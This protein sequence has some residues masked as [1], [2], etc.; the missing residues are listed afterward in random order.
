MKHPLE[1][2]SLTPIGYVFPLSRKRVF[3]KLS[4]N[5]VNGD[6]FAARFWQNKNHLKVKEARPAEVIIH[7]IMPSLSGQGHTKKGDFEFV[8]KQ[9]KSRDIMVL[10]TFMQWFGTNVGSCFIDTVPFG[11]KISHS[12][13]E[14]KEKFSFENKGDTIIASKIHIC[15][16]NCGPS[17]LAVGWHCQKTPESVTGRDRVV[18][19]ALMHWLGT[20]AGRQYMNEYRRYIKRICTLAHKKR[21]ELVKAA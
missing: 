2:S 1:N 16:E 19:N 6:Y 14:F 18:V 20:K 15:T 8:G 3:Q 9:Y 7:S 4:N 12:L 5:F 11:V 17:F 13:R 21:L 10:S